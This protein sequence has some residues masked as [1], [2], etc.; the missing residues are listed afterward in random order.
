MLMA[1]AKQHVMTTTN[2]IEQSRLHVTNDQ[3][4]RAGH[5]LSTRERLVRNAA[6][7]QKIS[8][9]G[10]ACHAGCVGCV[11]KEM[12]KCVLYYIIAVVKC[13]R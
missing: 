9:R 11:V 4:P 8:S 3:F 1:T 2:A 12:L 5:K 10:Q 6:Q 7:C 13:I